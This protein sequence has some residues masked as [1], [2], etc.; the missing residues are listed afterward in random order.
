[1]LNLQQ[2]TIVGCGLLGGSFA[3]ALRRIGFTGRIT[4]FGGSRSIAVA[5]ERGI[6]DAVEASFAAGEGCAS[7]LLFLAAPIGGIIDFLKKYSHQIEPGALVTDAGST[8]VEI[9]RIAQTA[10]PASVA[11]PSPNYGPTAATVQ[12]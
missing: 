6:V 2:I 4:A 11:K 5:V 9:C 7:D 1:M 8:K 3:L 10:L 12:R